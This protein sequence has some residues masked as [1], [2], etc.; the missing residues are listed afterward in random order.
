MGLQA[1][2]A[3]GEALG[4]QACGVEG[5]EVATV[6]DGQANAAL[7]GTASQAI[8]DPTSAPADER[9]LV[10]SVLSLWRAQKSVERKQRRTRE[11][12]RALRARLGKQLAALKALHAK[13]GR[14]GQWTAQLTARGIPRA[15]ADRYV[16][17]HERLTQGKIASRPT[18]AITTRTTADVQALARKHAINLRRHLVTA[19]VAEEFIVRIS[20]ALRAK[21]GA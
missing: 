20:L 14:N 5:M 7:S 21:L 11:E 16:A 10:I 6:F 18:E 3:Q 2:V 1:N 13:T 17:L 19:E 15:T 4:G 9:D 12:L 8:G